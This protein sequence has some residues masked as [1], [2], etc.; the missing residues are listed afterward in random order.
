[1]LCCSNNGALESVEWFLAVYAYMIYYDIFLHRNNL[2]LCFSPSSVVILKKPKD[3]D[4][5]NNAGGGT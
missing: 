2:F 4:S 5:E 3:E 1:M